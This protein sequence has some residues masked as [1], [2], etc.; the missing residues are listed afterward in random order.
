MERIS[1]IYFLQSYDNVCR[2][3]VVLGE[4]LQLKG[5]GGGGSWYY[6]IM[7]SGGASEEEAG[8]VNSCLP[9]L[10]FYC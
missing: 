4:L 6:D 3:F 9:I 5:A 8:I 1:I 10:F 2:A 7:I